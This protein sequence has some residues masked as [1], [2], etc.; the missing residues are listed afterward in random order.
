MKYNDDVYKIS[1]SKLVGWL[2]PK[3]Y[4]HPKIFAWIRALVGVFDVLHLDFLTH[5]N[6][7][8]FQIEVNGQVCR[9]EWGL[10]ERFDVLQKRI[11]ISDGTGGR[12]VTAYM[13]IDNKP[14]YLPKYLGVGGVDFVVNVPN[15]LNSLDADIKAFVT[16][17]M[18]PGRRFKIVYF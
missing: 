11:F 14:V 18:R 9:L 16:T 3:H 13:D 6:N 10:N 7:V 12:I 15:A 17:Y 4:F 5:R 2:I 8:I 1:W